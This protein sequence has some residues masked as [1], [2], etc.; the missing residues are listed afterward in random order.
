MTGT[1]AISS[2]WMSVCFSPY[3]FVWPEIVSRKEQYGSATHKGNG[4]IDPDLYP[5]DTEVVLVYRKE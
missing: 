3:S 5:I 1:D 2:H 4:I